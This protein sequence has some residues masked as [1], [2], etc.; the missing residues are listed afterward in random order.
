MENFLVDKEAD[1][2]SALSYLLYKYIC[3]NYV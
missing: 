2:N 3:I 1:Y